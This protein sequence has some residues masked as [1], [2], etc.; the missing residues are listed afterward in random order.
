MT[1]AQERKVQRE[2]LEQVRAETLEIVLTGVCPD[3]DSAL[4]RNLALHGWWQCEQYGDGHFRARPDE[5]QC[6]WQGFTA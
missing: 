3:C 2:K 4:K 6:D 5:P 1:A